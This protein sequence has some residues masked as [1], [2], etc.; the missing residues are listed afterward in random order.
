[1][2]KEISV[3][4]LLNGTKKTESGSIVD[5][6][7]QLPEM[8]DN[9]TIAFRAIGLEDEIREIRK[10]LTLASTKA[11]VEYLTAKINAIKAMLSTLKLANETTSQIGD[12]EN[13]N[14][15]ESI[16]VSIKREIPEN[17]S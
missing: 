15:I 9:A 6:R 2:S 3:A 8:S 5:A 7:D 1:M 14:D 16:E 12:T 4:D 10:E 11:R 17:E 13:P